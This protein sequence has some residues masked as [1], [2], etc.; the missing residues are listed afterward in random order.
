MRGIGEPAWPGRSEAERHECDLHEWLLNVAFDDQVE[1]GF[2]LLCPYDVLGL[3]PATIAAARRNHPELQDSH[4]HAPSPDYAG[5]TS[6]RDPFA[7]EL[8]PPPDG[9]ER[10]SFEGRG[11]LD[12]VRRFVWSAAAEADLPAAGQADIVLSVNEL[13]ANTVRHGGGAG[14]VTSWR[15]DGTMVCQVEDAGRFDDP[16]VGRRRPTDDQLSGRG[17]WVVNQLCDLVQIRSTPTGSVVRARVP[18]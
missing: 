6:G 17:L 4:G 16:L 2:E 14:V 7:G 5:A 9:A 3:D 12:S 13:A 8:L 10:L 15:E 11:S 18:V 1:A